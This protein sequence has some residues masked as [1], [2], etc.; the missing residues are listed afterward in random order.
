MLE[1]STVYKIE[2]NSDAFKFIE[3][4]MEYTHTGVYNYKLDTKDNELQEVFIWN[5]FEPGS[6]PVLKKETRNISLIIA[7]E[8]IEE[9]IEHILRNKEFYTALYQEV[10]L[11]RYTIQKAVKKLEVIKMKVK[12][13]GHN[14]DNII[15]K[16]E[17][18]LKGEIGKHNSVQVDNII[19]E[20]DSFLVDR[21]FPSLGNGIVR[22]GCAEEKYC[23][24]DCYICP[25]HWLG[26]Q[27]EVYGMDVRK[28]TR[29]FI[30]NDFLQNYSNYNE[31]NCFSYYIGQIGGEYY[32]NLWIENGLVFR[33][34]LKQND[35]EVF[36]IEQYQIDNKVDIERLIDVLIKDIRLI[37]HSR[38]FGF[39]TNVETD[40]VTKKNNIDS[41]DPD[42]IFDENSIPF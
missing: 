5:S 39:C 22:Y 8:P 9:V 29:E 35:N 36:L 13:E 37:H 12:E 32:C 42:Y 23:H 2:N 18:L 34:I 24:S 15:Q 40:V 10:M 26:K 27:F 25:Y 31:S 38:S 21:G 33:Q 20:M 7:I 4:L 16:T 17:E 41:C 30:E 28:E 3:D 19:K 11:S 1:N 14:F 6:I